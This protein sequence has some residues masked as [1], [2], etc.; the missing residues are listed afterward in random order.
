[1]LTI[2]AALYRI[3]SHSRRR[4]VAQAWADVAATHAIVAAEWRGVTR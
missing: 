3:R 1:M 2:A 4:A